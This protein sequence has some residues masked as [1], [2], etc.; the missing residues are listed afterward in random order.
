MARPSS[1]AATPA[2]GRLRALSEACRELEP[3]L[4][5]GGGHD[6]IAK[7]HAQGQL[8]TGGTLTLNRAATPGTRAPALSGS[9]SNCWSA[10]WIGA[11][12]LSCL[13]GMVAFTLMSQT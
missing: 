11:A 5:L 1:E 7:Q 3:R 6:R 8:T 10:E 4:R 9:L 13:V 2:Q 12:F